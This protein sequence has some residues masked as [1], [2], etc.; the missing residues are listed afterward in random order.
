[1]Q[2]IIYNFDD[3]S[4]PSAKRSPLEHIYLLKKNTNDIEE[5]CLKLIFASFS[6]NENLKVNHKHWK[7]IYL[8]LK[9]EIAENG[10]PNNIY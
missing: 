4:A 8:R 2:F 6:A 10:S 7:Q 3:N 9:E 1:M 5:K